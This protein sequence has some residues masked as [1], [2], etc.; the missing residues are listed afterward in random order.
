MP[1]SDGLSSPYPAEDEKLELNADAVLTESIT[2]R[3]Y[4]AKAERL[5]EL[6]LEA[7]DWN[8]PQHIVPRLTEAEFLAAS[9]HLLDKITQLERE[10]A[11]LM[12]RIGSRRK[13]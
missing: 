3:E 11:S 8:C 1:I 7:L 2:D 5:F 4:G 9:P 10:N 6:K 12:E 13:D